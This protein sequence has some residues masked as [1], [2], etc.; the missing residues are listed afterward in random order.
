MIFFVYIFWSRKC[1]DFNPHEVL[2]FAVWE[3][4]AL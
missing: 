4:P 2:D 1:L 3:S